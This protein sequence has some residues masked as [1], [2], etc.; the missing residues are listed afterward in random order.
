M[1]GEELIREWKNEE[2]QARMVGWDFSHLAGRYIEETDLPWDYRS[3]VAGRLTAAMKLLDIDTG[4][5]EFLRALGHPYEL[6]AATEG[7]PP[8]IRLCEQELVPL[9]IDFRAADGNGPLPFADASFDIVLNRH[10]DYRPEEIF[11]LLKPGGIF[12]TQQVG[13]ENDREL[14]ELLLPGE[15]APAF[16]GQ[17]LA[18]AVTELAAAGF[19]VLEQEEAFRKIRFFDVGALVWFAR[20]IE[21]EFPNFSV[22]R[23]LD[24]LWKA[25][26]IV[27]T[28]GAIEGNIHRYLIAARKRTL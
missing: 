12:V 26:E 15:T 5:G 14:I 23:C 8:N 9:G 20:V 2:A 18:V 25:Q 13:A 7:Y 27:K 28:R 21:W 22:D 10:G 16:P 19:T 24:R 3:V 11:R 4:G 17:R 1:Y 6:T